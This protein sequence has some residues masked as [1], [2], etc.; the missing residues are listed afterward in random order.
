MSRV[1]SNVEQCVEVLCLQGCKHVRKSIAT[2]ERGQT[3]R[4]T[5]RLD[6]G[7]HAALLNELKAIMAVYG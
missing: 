2:L 5:R 1:G 4:E 3:L 6:A 7:E